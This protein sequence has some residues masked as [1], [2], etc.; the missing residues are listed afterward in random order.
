MSESEQSV[1]ILQR[2]FHPDRDRLLTA[3]PPE[4]YECLLP[5]LE[6]V[7]LPRNRI[8][9]EAGDANQYAYFRKNGMCTPDF[10]PK[11]SSIVWPTKSV[12]E[13]RG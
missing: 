7:W 2:A 5:N 12:P 13:L 3:L 11:I 10:E 9:Y 4:E 8:L 1:I 6:Q